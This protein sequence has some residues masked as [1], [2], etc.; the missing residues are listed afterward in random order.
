MKKKNPT[1]EE[2]VQQLE[3]L[4]AQIDNNELTLDQIGD[5]LK[6]AQSLIRFCKEKLYQ[7]DQEV[8]KILA[9]IEK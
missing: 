6:E 4:V 7:T 3:T 2:A 8:Q 1:Y 9:T 5:K